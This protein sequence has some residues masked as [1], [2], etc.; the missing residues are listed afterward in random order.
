MNLATDRCHCVHVL[1]MSVK[2]RLLYSTGPSVDLQH[3]G[4]GL[5]LGGG[6]GGG[7]LKKSKKVLSRFREFLGGY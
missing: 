6:G 4:K 1:F 2:Q 3:S 7:S 5:K